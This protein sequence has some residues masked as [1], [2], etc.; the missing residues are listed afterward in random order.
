[1]AFYAVNIYKKYVLTSSAVTKGKKHNRE[2]LQHIHFQ[3]KEIQLL[4]L[5]SLRIRIRI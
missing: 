4:F 1:M 5:Y 2:F 3:Q